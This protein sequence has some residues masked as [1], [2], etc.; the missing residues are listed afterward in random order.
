MEKIIARSLLAQTTEHLWDNLRGK[1]ILVFDD[2]ELETNWKESVYSSYV[3][4][5]HRMYPKTPLLM[6]HHLRTVLGK[7]RL[8]P[9]SN[10]TL[11]G[12][13]VWSVHDSDPDVSLDTLALQTYQK[14]NHM[15]NDL[16]LR[17]EEYVG[18]IDLMDF[19]KVLR[20][21]AI[22]EANNTVEATPE[23]IEQ[24]Y[25]KI[26]DNLGSDPVLRDNP[27]AKAGRSKIVNTGQLLQCIGPRGYLT[28]T[29]SRQFRNPVLRGYTDGIRL[30]HDHLIESR[31][32]AKS[33]LFSKKPLQDA[34][35]FSRRLQLMDMV[36]QNLHVG[37][38]GSNNYMLWTVKGPTYDAKGNETHAGDLPC[39]VGKLYLDEETGRL[40]AIHKGD[41]HLIGKTLKMR[42]VLECQH[43][44]PY[45]ICTT[46]FGEMS[47]AVPPNSN[48]GH[49]CCTS[50]TQKSSQMVLST[51]HLDTSAS[52]ETVVV[53]QTDRK[54][55]SPGPDGYSY[56]LE[57]SLRGKVKLILNVKQATNL[58]DIQEVK[59]ISDLNVHRI[60]SMTDICIS[61]DTGKMYEE[62]TM[63]VGFERRPASMSYAMLDYIRKYGW[64][65]DDRGNYVINL[66]H[67]DRAQP[68]LVL[69]LLHYNMSDHSRDIAQLLESTVGELKR[70]DQVVSP[71]SMLNELYELVNSK[72]DVNLA[73]L[74]VVIYGIT[75]ISAEEMNYHLPKPWT[76][77]GV[78]IRAT[79][80]AYRSLAPAMAFEAHRD[81]LTSPTSFLLQDR[82]DHPL[83]ALLEPRAVL[84]D[85]L[86]Q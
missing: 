36:V 39:I 85:Y 40:K 75:I 27:L 42:G 71:I 64:D 12:N 81:I 32:A 55:I 53:Q 66:E 68:F 62:V 33:L 23:S 57:K 56:V 41:K 48:I 78:G 51:K 44:D 86:T 37:D 63:M 4:D 65:I 38:C 61:V 7:N 21:P 83:D 35:Y 26:M 8:S 17:L 43:P 67:W 30:F 18:S 46:C 11:I 47:L 13:V 29:D 45:G 80:M 50:M 2:G 59:N 49:M 74:E 77:C 84:Q 31:S 69:P 25:K 28:D 20:S 70:R 82:P 34:E 58:T 10:L 54:Y 73:I 5:F 9:S 3:W 52:V 22:A 6:K 16:S 14:V 79:L 60:S 19:I 76:D 15:Y 1:F 72:L 24:T